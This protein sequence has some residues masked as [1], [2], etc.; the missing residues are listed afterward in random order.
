MMLP[1]VSVCIAS[2]N[3]GC[4]LAETFSSILAQTYQDFEIVVVDDESTDDSV[5]II[6]RF[7]RQYPDKIRF[8]QHADRRN[9]GVSRTTNLA[10]EKSRGQY[11]AFIGSDDIWRNNLLEVEV[12]ALQRNPQH[13][14]VYA[15][16]LAVDKERNSLG[17]IYG[18]AVHGNIAQRLI[19][20]NA[21]PALTALVSRAALDQ[22]GV[23]DD[24]LAYSDWH[25]WIRISHEFPILFV[26]QVLAERREHGQNM[27]LGSEERDVHYQL[28]VLR[29]LEKQPWFEDVRLAVGVRKTLELLRL[30]EYHLAGVCLNEALI[31][32]AT[33]PSLKTRL[34]RVALD[35][36]LAHFLTD[37]DMEKSLLE[38]VAPLRSH[39]GRRTI[40]GEYY[41]AREF[42]AF[43]SGDFAMARY[44]YAR[45]IFY[46]PKFL[47]NLGMMRV[48]LKR[49]FNT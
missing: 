46:R 21:I 20:N 30:K 39:P 15:K 3:H 45:A 43:R 25:L 16:A 6:E 7:V 22:C 33:M 36:I 12:D 24:N 13:G 27:S 34:D 28:D 32:K 2:Y 35:R 10:V 14:L 41:A 17:R 31:S 44:C 48:L 11:I 23:F 47:I 38:F 18:A 19:L 1:K 5:K 4:Y 49:K 42:L 26:D 37:V 8:Y 29:A 9:H 40:L